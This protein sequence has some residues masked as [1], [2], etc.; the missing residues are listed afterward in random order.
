MEA[1]ARLLNEKRDA[2]KRRQKWLSITAALFFGGAFVATIVF[3][4]SPGDGE[5]QFKKCEN[6]DDCPLLMICK[7]GRCD[8]K[9]DGCDDGCPEGFSCE[10]KSEG[11]VKCQ[12]VD[13]SATAKAFQIFLVGGLLLLGVST[14]V[15][16]FF[17]K[18]SRDTE[19]TK[20]NERLGERVR[21][22]ELQDRDRLEGRIR[23]L[24]EE[25]R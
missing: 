5:P 24:E 25:R 14:I 13:S 6:E 20:E 12:P 3:L 19:T 8:V 17:S 21:S 11:G 10:K 9:D 16:F 1:D 22:L 4:F 23:K 7:S 2:E 15:L 18:R